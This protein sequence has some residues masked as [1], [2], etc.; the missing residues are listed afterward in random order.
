MA[1]VLF[2]DVVGFTPMT[3]R[4]LPEEILTIIKPALRMFVDVVDRHGGKMANFGGDSIMALFGV[5]TE[6]PDDAVRAVRAALEIQANVAA[7]ARKLKQSQ[8]M[9]FSA[10]V[11]LDTG[12][13]VLGEIGGEQRAEHTALGDAVNLAQR[14]ETLA[15][16]G[17]IV[18]SEHTYRQVRGWFKTESLGHIQVEGKSRPVK[19][20]RVLGERTNKR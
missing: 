3:E 15:Q 9:D 5:P 14:M 18:I 11:G 2:A 13:V 19:A 8:G 17:T 7:Y 12:I 10:R 4:H 20:Y 6:E 16:P 1:T